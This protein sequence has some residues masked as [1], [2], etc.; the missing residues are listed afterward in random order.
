M[1][2]KYGRARDRSSRAIPPP[3]PP[4]GPCSRLRI[5]STPRPR[6]PPPP[7]ARPSAFGITALGSRK[8]P[9]HGAAI[10]QFTRRLC[11]GR[12][13]PP[14]GGAVRV[15][16]WCSPWR[17]PAPARQACM[18]PASPAT[19]RALTLASGPTTPAVAL[20]LILRP[21]AATHRCPPVALQGGSLWR[22]A[23][24][25]ALAARRVPAICAAPNRVA[26]AP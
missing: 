10:R 2:R 11:Y 13:H 17:G 16:S 12:S 4:R 9:G 23:V 21:C 20:S 14:C 22:T 18:C 5:Y 7:P 8:L 19:N 26:T 15:D 25:R 3:A 6:R 1:S 24:P